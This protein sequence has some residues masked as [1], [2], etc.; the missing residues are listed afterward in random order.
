MEFC[1]GGD[2][3]ALIKR[4]KRDKDYVSEDRIWKVLA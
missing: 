3:A 2:M 4:S 1:E